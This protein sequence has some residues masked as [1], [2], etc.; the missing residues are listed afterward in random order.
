MRP[1]IDRLKHN[2]P[3]KNPYLNEI[4]KKYLKSFEIAVLV[5]EV[6]KK[7]YSIDYNEDEIAYIALHIEA[8]VERSKELEIKNIA[9][10][11]VTGIGTSQFV[12]SKLRNSF[13]SHFKFHAISA[14][15][16]VKPK[17]FKQY[18]LI[19]S[20]V[21][22]DIENRV[23]II[24]PILSDDQMDKIEYLLNAQRVENHSKKT[25][26]H[27]FDKENIHIFNT[28]MT[29][30]DMIIQG[31]ENLVKKNYVTDSFEASVFEREAIASTAFGNIAIPHGHV[32]HVKKPTISILTCN[33]AVD[34]D[35]VDVKIVFLISLNQ[36]V[37]KEMNAIFDFLYDL[38]SNLEKIEKISLAKSSEEI[39]KIIQGEL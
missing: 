30:E 23:Y 37:R 28:T 9:V 36:S 14:E 35:G 29:K 39:L 17:N 8:H 22:L 26:K 16:I 10:V 5:N 25:Y 13:K 18:D 11:C 33:N 20:T 19:L 32:N 15:D 1:S 2:L 27:I 21:P 38:T 12:M 31:C 7:N 24:N 34:W 3:V 4:K 6:L